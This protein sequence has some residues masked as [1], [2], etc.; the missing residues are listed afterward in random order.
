[1]PDVRAEDAA[2]RRVLQP[3]DHAAR[4]AP[5]DAHL[6]RQPEPPGFVSEDVDDLPE[7][8]ELDRVE[9][10]VAVG[11]VDPMDA[12][13]VEPPD[14]LAE[15]ARVETVIRVEWGGDRRPNAVQVLAG[16][17]IVDCQCFHPAALCS[18]WANGGQSSCRVL[19][20]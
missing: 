20:D 6:R 16:Q 10:T 13:R 14:I 8:R 9:L 2:L 17:L 19:G 4:I 15:D 12:S 11:G 1:M 5:G 18:A 7:L 3:I